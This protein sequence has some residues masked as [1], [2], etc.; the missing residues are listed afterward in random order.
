MKKKKKR[1][2]RSRPNVNIF[3][4]TFSSVCIVNFEQVNA[5]WVQC[6]FLISNYGIF[7]N[8]NKSNPTEMNYF[9]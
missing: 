3:Y 1:N 7:Q 4:T 9:E 8:G 5:D 6:V 2:R